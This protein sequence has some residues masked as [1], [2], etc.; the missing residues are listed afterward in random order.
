MIVVTGTMEENG[1]GKKRG[2]LAAND[3]QINRP[4]AAREESSRYHATRKDWYKAMVVLCRR[5]FPG[6]SIK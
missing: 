5:G 6:R 4:L 2:G 3:D 1:E